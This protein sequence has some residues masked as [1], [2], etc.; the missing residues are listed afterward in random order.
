MVSRYVQ[1]ELNLPFANL[2]GGAPTTLVRVL[3]ELELDA[4]ILKLTQFLLRIYIL[5]FLVHDPKNS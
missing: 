2:V 5:S 3:L 4:F 1:K